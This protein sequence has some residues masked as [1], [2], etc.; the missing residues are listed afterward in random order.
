MTP[1]PQKSQSKTVL[2]A[3]GL[4]GLLLVLIMGIELQKNSVYFL[5]PKEA[6][7]Q[8]AQLQDKTIRVGGMV[9]VGSLI[10]EASSLKAEFILSNLKQTRIAVSYVGLLPDMFK[11]G[12]GVVL[13]GSISE[14]GRKFDAHKLMVK[15]SEEYVQPDAHNTLDTEL[16]KKSLLKEPPKP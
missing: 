13:E 11:E 6:Q 8:A 15:H 9:E 4:G 3:A 14:S 2:W 7:S 10:T 16:L 12:S 1:S 5:T